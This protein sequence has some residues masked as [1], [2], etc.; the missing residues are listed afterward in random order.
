MPLINLSVIY[1]LRKYGVPFDN[2]FEKWTRGTSYL[3]IN[4]FRKRYL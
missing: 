4:P 1:L 3:N 2:Y